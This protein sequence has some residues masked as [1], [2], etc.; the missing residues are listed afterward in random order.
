MGGKKTYLISG[1][2]RVALGHPSPLSTPAHCPLHPFISAG[3][4][5]PMFGI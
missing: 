4:E 1:Y 5:D 3:D 2:S